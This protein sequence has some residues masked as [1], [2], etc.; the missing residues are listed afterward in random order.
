MCRTSLTLIPTLNH[1][2]HV[3][4]RLQS[5]QKLLSSLNSAEALKYLF[6]KELNYD[7]A[8]RRL[9]RRGW[10]EQAGGALAADPEVFATAA[11]EGFHVIYARLNSDQLDRS[12]ERTVVTR[13]LQEHPYALFV[14]CNA[15]QDRWHFLNVKQ[16]PE[17][18]EPAD[19]SEPADAAQP[20]DAGE[21]HGPARRRVFRRIT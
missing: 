13:L 15:R 6:W 12:L 16:S 7:R 20:A 18:A 17:A 5:I 2:P 14:F 10:S 19:A 4:N 11:A 8:E 3:P 1:Q 21:P 9:S